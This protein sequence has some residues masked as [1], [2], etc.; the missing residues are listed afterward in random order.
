[1]FVGFALPPMRIRLP[2]LSDV[3]TVDPVRR[4]QP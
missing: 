1:M 4:R 3:K 2:K